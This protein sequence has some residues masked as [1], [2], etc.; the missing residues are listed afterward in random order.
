MA[1]F[2]L[3]FFFFRYDETGRE[4][5]ALL[6]ENIFVLRQLADDVFVVV[7]DGD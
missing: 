6:D 1:R 5:A 4:T 7:P 2:Y 3:F